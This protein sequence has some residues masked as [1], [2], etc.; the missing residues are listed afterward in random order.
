MGI[1]DGKVVA[2][3]GAGRGI[4]RAVAQGLAA[5]GA[6]VVVN[7]YGVAVDGTAPTSE[8]ASGVVR[9]IEA[10]GGKAIANAASVTTMAGG[11]SIV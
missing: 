5:N 9:E 10:A 1:L 4:G 11:A 7:D 3:T 2:V 6:K 8:V